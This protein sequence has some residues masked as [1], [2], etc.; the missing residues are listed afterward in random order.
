MR[1][2]QEPLQ[3]SSAGDDAT[4][5]AAAA[6]APWPVRM[7]RP[8]PSPRPGPASVSATQALQHSHAGDVPGSP[9]LYGP[10][11]G[12]CHHPCTRSCVR[13]CWPGDGGGLAVCSI[14]P[15]SSPCS[16]AAQ[17]RTCMANSER[18]FERARIPASE[19]VVAGAR[20]HRQAV[21][22]ARVGLTGRGMPKIWESLE[23]TVSRI[24]AKPRTDT[25]RTDSTPLRRRQ[26]RRSLWYLRCMPAGQSVPREPL[27]RE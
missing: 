4:G 11:F 9:Q 22:Q 3:R 18:G 5:S 14:V 10:P 1:V 16:S 21:Q 23:L 17:L 2:A 26:T 25:V 24:P 7:L 8:L 15:S 19:A 6:R 27:P 12:T 13:I 20:T